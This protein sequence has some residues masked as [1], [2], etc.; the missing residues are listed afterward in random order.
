MQVE[1]I[2]AELATSLRLG[3]HFLFCTTI[4]HSCKE[5]I[6]INSLDGFLTIIIREEARGRAP[7]LKFPDLGLMTPGP[8]AVSKTRVSSLG[9][10]LT[11]NP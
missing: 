6:I 5:E 10:I 3:S 9:I 8:L 7:Q 4:L 2:Q 11:S 1:P